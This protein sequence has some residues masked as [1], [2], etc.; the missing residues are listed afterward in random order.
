MT[1]MLSLAVITFLVLLSACT[2]C[3]KGTINCPAIPFIHDP[4]VIT[5]P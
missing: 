3:G 1:G 2:A 5:Y 4:D